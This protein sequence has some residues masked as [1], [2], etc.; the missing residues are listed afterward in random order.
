VPISARNAGQA[1]I[2]LALGLYFTPEALARLAQYVGALAASVALAVLLGF[3]FAFALHRLAGMAAPTAYFAGAI[4]GATEMALQGERHGADVEAIVATHSLRVVLVVLL[5][6]WATF[7]VTAWVA[8]RE[9]NVAGAALVA[10]YTILEAVLLAW[11][12][13]FNVP[14][15]TAWTFLGAATLF[16][17]VYNLLACD[18]IAE[19]LVS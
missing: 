18:W 10:I 6:P 7:F 17:G 15:V 9:S 3:A 19:K 12:F 14:G 5:V 2:G 4:G 1:I 8:R 13:N 11:L 16:A